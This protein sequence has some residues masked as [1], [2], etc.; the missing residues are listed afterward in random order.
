MKFSLIISLVFLMAVGLGGANSFAADLG[1]QSGATANTEVQSCDAS[2]QS[3][4]SSQASGEIAQI[5]TGDVIRFLE[6]PETDPQ[7]WIQCT[8]DSACGTWKCCGNHCKNVVT[9]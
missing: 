2:R 9:C 8:T 3:C 5:K 1:A 6:R 4:K 7:T